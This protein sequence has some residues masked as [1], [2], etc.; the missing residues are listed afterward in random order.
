MGYHFRLGDGYLMGHEIGWWVVV[1]RNVG[2]FRNLSSFCRA[3]FFRILVSGYLI[4]TLILADT[5]KPKPQ[6]SKPTIRL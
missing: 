5:L 2:A 6:T 1:S 3:P 4:E